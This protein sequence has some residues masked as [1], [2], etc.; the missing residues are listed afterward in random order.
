M[1]RHLAQILLAILI[2]FFIP[3]FAAYLDYYD[4][5]GRD[6][7]ACD[8]GFENSD[9]DNCSMDRQDESV[10]FLLGVLS[11]T[12]TSSLDLLGEPPLLSLATCPLGNK[13][14]TLRC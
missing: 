5:A 9:P 11:V 3:G 2:S 14:F 8:I 13:T 7:F 6:F 12:S 10:G 4:L 1:N